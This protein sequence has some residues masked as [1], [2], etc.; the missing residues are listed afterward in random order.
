MV[1]PDLVSRLKGHKWQVSSVDFHPAGEMLVSG[2][3]DRTIR[4]WDIMETKELRIFDQDTHTQPITCVKWHP[5]GVLLASTS[6]DN[7]TC[8]WDASSGKKVRSLRE[9]FGWV[10]HCSFSPDR[11]K[12][13]TCSWDKTVRLWDP[14]TGELISTLRGHSKG[15]WSCA[16]YPV[17]HTSALLASAGEDCTARLWDTRSRKV[18]LTLAGGHADAVYSVAWSHDGSM[19]ATGSSDKTVS[20]ILCSHCVSWLASVFFSRENFIYLSAFVE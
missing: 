4:I 10:M 11:T 1:V 2:S 7:T 17:G 19:V 13:A 8:L 15:V 3:W 14:N 20:L 18:A 9:H 6:A 16:F 5:N 12:L